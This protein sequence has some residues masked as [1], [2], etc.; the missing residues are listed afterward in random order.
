MRD[1]EAAILV[2]GWGFWMET[3]LERKE[4]RMD[5]RPGIER[6]EG[7]TVASI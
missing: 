5:R 6:F 2:L 4:R 1:W 3:S 7:N